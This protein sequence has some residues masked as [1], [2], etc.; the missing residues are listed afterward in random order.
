MNK[1]W[2]SSLGDCEGKITREHLISKGL[3]LD[4]T[5]IVKGYSWCKDETIKVS[6]ASL[7]S[8][9]LCKKHNSLLSEIDRAGIHSFNILQKVE[10]ISKV[11]EKIRPK[12]WNVVKDEING[13]K[14]RKVVFKNFNKPQLSQRIYYRN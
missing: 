4:D 1:C 7:T 2:A 5:I 10:K 11:R 12:R 9:I 8:K 13:K 6:L 3:F 14:T